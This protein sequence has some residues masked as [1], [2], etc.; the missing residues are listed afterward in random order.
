[1]DFNDIFS[2]I[3]ERAT[4]NPPI[5]STVKFVV[6][7]RYIFVDGTGDQNIVAEK[8]QDAACTLTV[9]EKNFSRMMMGDLNPMLATMTG[10]MKIEGDMGLAMK[11]QSFI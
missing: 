6:D 10:E 1:M 4:V 3:K 9:S 7:D 11:L 8:D 5:G 2:A